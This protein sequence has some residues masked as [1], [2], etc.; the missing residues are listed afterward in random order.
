VG[1][2]G[3]EVAEGDVVAGEV[4]SDLVRYFFR[5]A[6]L[7]FFAGVKGAE[8]RVAGTERNSA[9]AAIPKSEGA[10]AGAVHG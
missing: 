10:H 1:E 8:V 7:D 3:A 4:E 5:V 6:A 9:L 2:G